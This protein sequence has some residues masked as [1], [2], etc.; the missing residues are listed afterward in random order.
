MTVI[1]KTTKNSAFLP[2]QQLFIQ[3]NLQKNDLLFHPDSA[4]M[5]HGVFVISEC[6]PSLL[7]SGL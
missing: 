3:N 6:L 7:N 5:C 2:I 4:G 1:H